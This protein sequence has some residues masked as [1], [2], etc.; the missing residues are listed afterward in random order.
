MAITYE[1]IERPTDA[2]VA[3]QE[4]I[5]SGTRIDVIEAPA[6][7]LP[8]LRVESIR[9]GRYELD[10]VSSIEV[11]P[12]FSRLYID[13]LAYTGGRLVLSVSGGDVKVTANSPASRLPRFAGG[14]RSSGD[15]PYTSASHPMIDVGGSG[16]SVAVIINISALEN[17]DDASVALQVSNDGSTWKNW[18]AY[19]PVAGAISAKE[20]LELPFRYIRLRPDEAV[21]GEL[22]LSGRVG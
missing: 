4:I 1:V 8:G 5:I 10:Q 6:E 16:L 9:A 7:A 11:P 12:G 17:P 13:W 22:T 20:V 21:R 18:K 3:G 14:F 15:A 19:N 2:L